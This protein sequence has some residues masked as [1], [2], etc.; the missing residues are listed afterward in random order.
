MP[1]AAPASLDAVEAACLDALVRAAHDKRSPLRWPVLATARPENA[2]A[3]ARIV[4][5]R[6]FQRSTRTAELWTDRRSDKVSELDT[7]PLATLHFFDRS[8]MVQMRARGPAQTV[9]GG[10]DWAKALARARQAGLDD[11]TTQA[12]PGTPL[13][14]AG[15]TRQLDLA[16]ENFTL[17]QV[18][19]ETLDW[20]SLSREGH[21]RAFLDWREGAAHSWRVP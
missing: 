14:E 18:S 4:V 17:L 16:E 6:S 8:R 11:Y 7:C 9:T 13:G 3:S 12:A 10:D 20:L 19:I 2:G 1:D 21:A 15:I 5:L